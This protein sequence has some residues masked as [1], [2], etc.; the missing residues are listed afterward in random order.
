MA[1]SV[2]TDHA[3]FSPGTPVVL[4]EKR[5]LQTGNYDVS[6][7]RKRFIIQDRIDDRP[8]LIHVVNNWFEEFRGR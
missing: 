3:A 2:T 8:L 4:F 7:D 1:A 5:S 6:A